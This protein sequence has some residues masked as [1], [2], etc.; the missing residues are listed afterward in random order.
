LT[1]ETVTEL[2]V[3]SEMNWVAKISVMKSAMRKPP[4][5]RMLKMRTLGNPTSNCVSNYADCDKLLKEAVTA[6]TLVH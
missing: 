4:L 3:M 1:V 2:L 6:T 5:S